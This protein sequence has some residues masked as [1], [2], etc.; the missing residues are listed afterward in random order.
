MYAIRYMSSS[1]AACGIIVWNVLDTLVSWVF[2]ISFFFFMFYW[3][4]DIIKML[5]SNQQW[6]GGKNLKEKRKKREEK[7][8]KKL[9]TK[10]CSEWTGMIAFVAVDVQYECVRLKIGD[11]T[12]IWSTVHTACWSLTNKDRIGC[13]LT[14]IYA[15]FDTLLSSNLNWWIVIFGAQFTLPVGPWLK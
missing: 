3:I 8:D 4:T 7:S 9:K 15:R 13:V 2:A 12:C 1:Q 6:L 11:F 14:S 5:T 10:L